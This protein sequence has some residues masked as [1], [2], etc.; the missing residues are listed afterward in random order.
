[1]SQNLNRHGLVSCFTRAAHKPPPRNPISTPQPRLGAQL[2][3]REMAEH[4][5]HGDLVARKSCDGFVS[6]KLKHSGGRPCDRCAK[7]ECA[8][9]SALRKTGR[10]CKI[11]DAPASLILVPERTDGRGG[12]SGRSGV[13]YK[14][15]FP[16]SSV[17]SGTE[18]SGLIP[19]R[20][21]SAFVR[22][23]LPM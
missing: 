3:S 21:L 4:A 20:F 15:R 22:H 7:P 8:Y 12:T 14:A 9:S 17:S 6:K 19:S 5:R 13:S 1:M 18:I 16:D 23:F 2:A 11:E 10:P